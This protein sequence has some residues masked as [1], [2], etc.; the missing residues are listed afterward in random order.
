[1]KDFVHE[2]QGG[3]GQLDGLLRLPLQGLLAPNQK[4]MINPS[5][6]TVTLVS[7]AP[8]GE[9]QFIAQQQFSP[10]GMRVL[11]PLLEAHP[12]YCPYEV[13]LASLCSL[14]L[15]EARRQLQEMWDISIRQ[16]RRA[17]NSLRAGLAAFGLGIRTIFSDGYQVEALR[18]KRRSHASSQPA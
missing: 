1:M 12:D 2:A 14:P 9:T 7:T 3:E 13:L 6:R 5:I 16:V 17:I 11:I 8:D 10:N 15:E 18:K 4:L